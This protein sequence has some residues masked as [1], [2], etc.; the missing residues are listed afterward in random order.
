[1]GR[2][3]GEQASAE[4]IELIR[5][6]KLEYI[7]NYVDGID[8]LALNEQGIDRKRL[9]SVLESYYRKVVED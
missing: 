5:K 9:F 3:A 2:G 1:M 4:A 6:S 7:R 8:Q